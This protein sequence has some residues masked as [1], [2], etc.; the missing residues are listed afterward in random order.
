M[1]AQLRSVDVLIMLLALAACGKSPPQAAAE[2]QQHPRPVRVQSVALIPREQAVT[3]SGTVQARVQANLAF[4]VGGKVIERPVDIGNNVK[5]GQVLARLDP[6]DLRLSLETAEHVVR[7]ALADAANARSEF[8]RYQQLGRGSP[9]FIAAEFDKRQA[10]LDGTEARLAQAQRQLS[11]ARDQL[12]YAELRADADGVITA[13]PVEVGQVVTAGQT[14]AALAH[15]AETEIVVDVPENR[16]PD[17]R[18]AKDIAVSLWSAPDQVLHGHVREV[19]A[20][21]DPASR[22][23]MVKVAVVDPVAGELG[24]GMTASV[25][26]AHPAG[27]PVAMLPAAAI[28]DKGGSPAVWVFDPARQRASLR[29]V[30]IEAWRGDGQAV[31]SD[32]LAQGDQVV[33]AGA[34]LLDPD[35][36]VV[37]WAGPTR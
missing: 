26:F 24:L 16:L 6:K 9:A 22:T 37:A 35:L 12:D 32:G 15:T 1:V 2:Q 7:A 13:L 18:A 28:M 14:V 34:S 11:L 20:L 25:R 23:F 19:G 10:A 4:R 5:T 36:P 21:A 29:P 30:R 31:V 8:A 3:Y 33:T 17:I 27:A